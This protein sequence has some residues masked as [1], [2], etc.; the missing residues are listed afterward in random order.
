MYCTKCGNKLKEDAL[1]CPKCGSRVV[2]QNNIN[3]EEIDLINNQLNKENNT[4]NMLL[5]LLL[6]ICFILI[7]LIIL[8]IV[9]KPNRTNLES[10][11]INK[12]I[13]KFFSK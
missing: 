8:S 13:I 9:S 1:F 4:S 10:S 6:P 11:I 2:K 5:N 7:I 12:N 3:K